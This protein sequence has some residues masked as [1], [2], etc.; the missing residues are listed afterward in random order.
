LA[1]TVLVAGLTLAGAQTAR[2]LAT[3]FHR[4]VAAHGYDPWW[5]E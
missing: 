2:R 5:A 4:L 3:A 1:L